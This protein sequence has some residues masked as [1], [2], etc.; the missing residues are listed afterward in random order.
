MRPIF[1]RCGA[2]LYA[3]P[4]SPRYGSPAE[5]RQHLRGILDAYGAD[6]GYLQYQGK[7]VIVFWNLPAVP[8]NPGQSPQQT[9]AAIRD[10]VDPGRKSIWIGEG[11]DTNAATGTITYLHR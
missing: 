7:P 3:L 4:P 8:R 9:W 1:R 11:A 10:S 5:L 2:R 6:P